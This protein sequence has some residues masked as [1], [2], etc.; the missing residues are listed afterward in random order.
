MPVLTFFS[1]EVFGKCD[2]SG[3]MVVSWHI[4]KHFLG[5]EIFILKS[6][7]SNFFQFLGVS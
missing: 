6:M 5:K 3:E 2:W 4:W 1:I 7:K